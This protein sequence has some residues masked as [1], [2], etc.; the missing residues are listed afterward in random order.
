MELSNKESA[1]KTI[2][3][4]QNFMLDEHALKLS[5][6]T[7]NVS[8]AET[9]QKKEKLL[10][11]RKVNESELAKSENEDVKSNKLM[12]KNLAFECT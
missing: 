9:Q 10:K 12:V 6:S 7:K 1:E 11:K 2:K 8:E 5:L 4:L 3:K